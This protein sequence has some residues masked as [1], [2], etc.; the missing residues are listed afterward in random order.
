[1]IGTKLNFITGNRNKLAEVQTILGKV[2]AVDNQVVDI[3]EI[4][5]TVEE[6]AEKKATCAAQAVISSLSTLVYI[7]CIFISSRL[8]R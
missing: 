5:G 4:Q 6:I 7:S 8:S 1:M 3:P 2:I